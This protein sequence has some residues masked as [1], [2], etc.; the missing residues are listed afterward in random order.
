MRW[1]CSPSTSPHSA[2]HA[3]A[4]SRRTW[5]R[6]RAPACSTSHSR[7]PTSSL[8][9]G[10]CTPT[11]TLAALSSCLA[12]V[13]S[14][15]RSCPTRSG[16]HSHLSSTRLW[17]SWVSW[18]TRMTRASCCRS[19]QSHWVTAPLSSSRLLSVSAACARC[20]PLPRLSPRH[21]LCWSRR[22]GVE[23]S[24]RATSASCSRGL[25]TTRGGWPSGTHSERAGRLKGYQYGL[26]RVGGRCANQV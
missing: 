16:T 24:A 25:R 15:T 8:P 4:R 19:S 1:C 23:A 10:P 9:C 26:Y 3:R 12:P 21:P 22:P 17:R 20:R 6:T 7:P 11:A 13:T 18:L 2:H 14:T 5:S